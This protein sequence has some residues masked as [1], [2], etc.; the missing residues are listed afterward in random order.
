M[1]Y[2][3]GCS[4]MGGLL[5]KLDVLWLVKG[6]NV[7]YRGEWRGGGCTGGTVVG[8]FGVAPCWRLYW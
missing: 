4:L 2:F 5:E 6:V 1:L 3:Q 8:N 7:V